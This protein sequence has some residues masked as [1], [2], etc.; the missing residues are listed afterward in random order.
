MPTDRRH[1]RKTPRQ[2]RSLVT[3]GIILDATALVLV[4]EGYDRA[5]TNR[6]AERAGVSIGSLYQYFPNR[7]ALLR[8][9]HSR[10][11]KQISDGIWRILAERDE[12]QPIREMLT[13]GVR[14]TIN[15]H[16]NF[17]PL[18]Q[19][20]METASG[21]IPVQWPAERWPQK[22]AVIRGILDKHAGEL[23]TDFNVEAGTLLLP[24]MVGSAV[25][26]AIAFRPDALASGELERELS[27]MLSYYLT[28][29]R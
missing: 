7:D 12:M 22:H 6:I 13:I 25:D 28:G 19:V 26:A 20:L 17:L 8:A 16:A 1:H 29:E 15:Q 21:R 18:L 23:R 24:R 27:T 4:E 11:D 14:T 9:L 5:T 10:T 2:A 3:V